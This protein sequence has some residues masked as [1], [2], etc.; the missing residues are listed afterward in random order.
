MKGE[1]AMNYTLFIADLHLQ[2]SQSEKTNAFL[3]FLTTTVLKADALYILGDFFEIWIGDDD[4][5][6][7]NE[8]IKAALKKCKTPIYF[9]HGNRDFLIS[10]KFAQETGCQLIEDPTKIDLYGIPTLLTHGD[11]LCSKDISYM[12]YRKFAHNPKYNKLFLL[13][14]LKLRKYI[15]NLLRMKSKKAQTL[16][17][18]AAKDVVAETVIKLMQE[19][20]VTQLIHG[21]THRPAI[22][23]IETGKRITLP[24]WHNSATYIYAHAAGQLDLVP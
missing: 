15:A 8:K 4:D 18:T 22:H 24:P 3:K 13:L 11:L 21:H 19:Y 9:M 5:S 1:R 10:K 6:P 14:P 12:K 17:S 23:D 16:K 2:E 20:Q 7:F